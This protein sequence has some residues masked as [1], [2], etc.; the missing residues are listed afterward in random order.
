MSL[1]YDVS[2]VYG[3]YGNLEYETLGQTDHQIGQSLSI[4]PQTSEVTELVCILLPETQ[5]RQPVA[6]QRLVKADVSHTVVVTRSHMRLL[7][8]KNPLHA[9]LDTNG[10]LDGRLQCRIDIRPLVGCSVVHVVMLLP[11]LFLLVKAVLHAR[12]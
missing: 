4:L 8:S 3:R 2:I 1:T 9:M 10:L 7:A 12:K 6:V 11:I 5:L